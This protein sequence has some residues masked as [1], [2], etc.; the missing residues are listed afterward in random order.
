MS[1][2]PSV[3]SWIVACAAYRAVRGAEPLEGRTVI[4]VDDGLATGA[5]AEAALRVVRARDAARIVLAV[6]VA[7][8]DT[9]ARL[10]GAADEVIALATPYD[11]VAIGLHYD[12]FTQ[13]TDDEVLAATNR[14][15]TLRRRQA[16]AAS[17]T[18]R[19]RSRRPASRRPSR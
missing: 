13:T 15:L 3:R 6:P 14:C 19:M 11:M 8:P 17:T 16:S 1:R 10:K 9:V 4:V 12:D 2:R 18:R 7:P 5:T